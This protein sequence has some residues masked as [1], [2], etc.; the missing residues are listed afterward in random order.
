M[1]HKEVSLIA[2]LKGSSNPE[3]L[4]PGCSCYDH[5]HGGC[6]YDSCCLVEQGKRCPWFEKAVLPTSADIG[7]QEHIYSLYEEHIDMP[8]LLARKDARL[9]TDCLTVELSARQRY[10]PDCTRKRRQAT[11]RPARHRKA[12]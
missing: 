4:I 1:R 8:G 11:Y 6:L 5:A 12:G 7:Q 10:C 9:C 3:H 2:F